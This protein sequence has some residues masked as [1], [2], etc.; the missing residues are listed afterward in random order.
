MTDRQQRTIPKTGPEAREKRRDPNAP[1]KPR[2]A[3]TLFLKDHSE[4]VNREHAALSFRE[5]STILG[6]L[7]TEVGPAVQEECAQKAQDDR[8]RYDTEMK[9]Y[10]A[11]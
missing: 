11:R 1:K 4:Q 6:Q 2:S 5:R 3:Y 8:Q 10:Q 7:W 9:A